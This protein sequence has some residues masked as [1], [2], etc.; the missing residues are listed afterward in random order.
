VVLEATEQ[1]HM[2][3]S[4]QLLLRLLRSNKGCCQQTGPLPWHS[5]IA[6][7]QLVHKIEQNCIQPYS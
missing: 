1:Y 4:K 6:F 3:G 5:G 7:V 2:Y